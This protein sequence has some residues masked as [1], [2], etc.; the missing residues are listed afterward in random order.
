M[1]ALLA[2]PARRCAI[3]SANRARAEQ[4]YGEEKMFQAYAALFGK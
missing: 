3:G 1:A 2:D 4:E